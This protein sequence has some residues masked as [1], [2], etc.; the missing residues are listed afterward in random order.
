MIW[1]PFARSATRACR[2]SK[3]GSKYTPI[4][5]ERVRELANHLPAQVLLPREDLGE[6]GPGDH[7]VPAEL[8][9]CRSGKK[10]AG[11]I[12]GSPGEA[13]QC[14]VSSPP[15]ASAFEVCLRRQKPRRL[16]KN[17]ETTRCGR[18]VPI[19]NDGDERIFAL[20][21]GQSAEFDWRWEGAIAFRSRVID[22]FGCVLLSKDVWHRRFVRV[23]RDYSSKSEMISTMTRMASSRRHLSRSRVTVPKLL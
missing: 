3:V 7:R 12:K 8:R 19:S 2:M 16:M 4:H 13:F 11:R 21:V 1:K 14:F 17:K 20:E 6:R 15:Q 23:E 9:L 10:K 22:Q 18:I 5:S